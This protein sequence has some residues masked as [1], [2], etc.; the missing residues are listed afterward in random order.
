MRLVN[1][2]G[3]LISM[4]ICFV[5]NIIFIT[6]S[7]HIEINECSIMRTFHNYPFMPLI[8]SV[9]NSR[10]L[11]YKILCKWKVWIKPW[12]CEK[13][14][15]IIKWSSIGHNYFKFSKD[16]ITDRTIKSNKY[17]FNFIWTPFIAKNYYCVK[18]WCHSVISFVMSLSQKVN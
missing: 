8:N 17:V 4:Q 6:K 11:F 15:P 10:A 1:L 13:I 2:V 14:W 5:I 3:F 7:I 18:V 9:E 12:F 16:R